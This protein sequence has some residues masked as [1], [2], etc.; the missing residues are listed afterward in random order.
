MSRTW[1]GYP[2]V[3]V[4]KLLRWQGHQTYDPVHASIPHQVSFPAWCNDRKV[5]NAWIAAVTEP[6]CAHCGTTFNLTVDHVVAKTFDPKLLNDPSN[7]QVLCR[8]CNSKKYNL[9]EP[10]LRHGSSYWDKPWSREQLAKLR[11]PQ[12]R[13]A[14]GKP[15]DPYY[16]DY[17]CQPFYSTSGL[18]YVIVWHT[19]TGKTLG[20]HALAHGINK[21][22]LKSLG[23][24]YPRVQK[25]LVLTPKDQYR[26]QLAKDL[27]TDAHKLLDVARPTVKR[28]SSDQHFRNSEVL[29]ADI[30]VACVATL[31]TMSPLALADAFSHFD[32]IVS[33]EAHFSTKRMSEF[34]LLARNSLF[35]AMT[36]TPIDAHGNPL[37]RMV[38]VD[39]WSKAE[40]DADYSTKSASIEPA[41]LG[42]SVVSSY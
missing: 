23:P 8:S 35:F 4:E 32:L 37:G 29:K 15:E 11:T 41:Q 42:L 26:T 36:A 18:I 6:A 17:F 7:W 5:F 25:I 3:A 28:A 39:K 31:N 30:V 24:R 1:D 22:R 12:R 19:G 33:D 16:A 21:I 40:A 38:C 34:A 27:A 13:L 2:C 14:M 9:P 20:I 10:G